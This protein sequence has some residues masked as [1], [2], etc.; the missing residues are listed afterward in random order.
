MPLMVI[1]QNIVC[2]NIDA[3]PYPNNIALA[4]FTKYVDVLGCFSIY[5]ES[6]ISDDKVLHAA[7]IA[8]ELLDNNEDGIVD[9]LLIRSQLILDNALMPIFSYEGSSAENIFFNNYNGDGVSA[10]LYKN[11][12][13]PSQPGHWGSDAS[14]EEILHTI[15]HVGHTNVY[16]ALFSLQPN[17]SQL[18]NAM[19]IARGGQFLSMPNPYPSSAWYHYDDFTCDY[20]CMAIEYIYW[21]IVSNMGILDDS[22]TASGIADEWEL[23][24]PYLLQVTDSLIFSLISNPQNLIPQFAPDGNYCPNVNFIS[25]NSVYK[26]NSVIVDLLGRKTTI[27]N[28]TLIIKIFDTGKVL[29][30]FIVK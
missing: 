1:G 13:D 6:T 30:S 29:K 21:A 9:D 11:E 20:E 25:E 28:N 16:P 2:F 5:A 24:S 19:D 17:S 7:A 23:Y 26:G 3:N 10:V 15:N 14:V 4:P 18:S 22:Q 27:K 8:A 12:I